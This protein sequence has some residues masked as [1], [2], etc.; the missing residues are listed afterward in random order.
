M[1]VEVIVDGVVHSAS[2][3]IEVEIQTQ[4]TFLQ[5][6]SFIPHVRGEAV[7]VDLG[8]G[9]NVIAL[10][11]SGPDGRNVSYPSEIVPRLFHVFYNDRD[12]PKLASLRGRRKIPESDLPT[13]V[14][15][16]DLGDPKTARVVK[17]AEFSQ[18]FGSGVRFSQTWI[19][20][21]DEPVT[22]NIEGKMP[23]W[24]GPLPWLKPLGGGAYVDTRRDGFRWQKEMFK[25]RS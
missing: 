10:L 25:R 22:Y 17:P 19:E 7:F 24:N 3:V 16:A 5:T 13:F 2:S 14:T 20:M 23:W 21:T 12:L 8:G 18:V 15:F 11:V 4:S 1:T 6:P 9:R